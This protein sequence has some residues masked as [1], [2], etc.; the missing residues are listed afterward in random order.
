M[1]PIEYETL[2]K[3]LYLRDNV[4]IV[5]YEYLYESDENAAD[6]NEIVVEFQID[7][8]EKVQEV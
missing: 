4:E 7:K 6:V 8:C 5:E 2:F 3:P 1:H